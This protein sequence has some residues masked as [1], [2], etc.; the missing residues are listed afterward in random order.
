[1][2]D[3]THTVLKFLSVKISIVSDLDTIV[4]CLLQTKIRV[5]IITTSPVL[6][7]VTAKKSYG[8]EPNCQINQISS[9]ILQTNKFY[10][11]CILKEIENDSLSFF[12][13]QSFADN[14]IRIHLELLFG[15]NASEQIGFLRKTG[16]SD[17]RLKL[18]RTMGDLEA[19]L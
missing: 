1:M 12:I 16:L 2:N 6:P 18:L 14:V 15:S 19:I 8:L 4:H 9:N 5:A 7:R 17:I 10:Q 3:V 13:S 11:K